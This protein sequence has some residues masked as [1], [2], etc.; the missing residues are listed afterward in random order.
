MGSLPMT[1]ETTT[2]PPDIELFHAFQSL[3]SWSTEQLKRLAKVVRIEQAPSG[4]LLVS[5][6]GRH[7]FGLFLLDGW[8]RLKRPD[9]VVEEVRSA[10]LEAREVLARGLPGACDV[11]S[12][13]P[14]RF[15]RL[16]N[17]L[18]QEIKN[19]EDDAMESVVHQMPVDGRAHDTAADIS[20]RLHE[21]LEQDRLRLPSLPEVAIRVTQALEDET[22]DAAAIAQIIQVD[23]AMTAKLI[24]AANSALY[25]RC[26]PVE[27]CASAVVR[28]G[29]GIT[30]KLIVSFA[31]RELF[32]S[33]SKPLQQRMWS[34]WKHSTRIASLCYLLARMDGRFDPEQAMLA[35]LLHDVGV[36]AVI[37]FIAQLQEPARQPEVVIEVIKQL[38]AESSAVI[39]QRWG[40]TKSFVT[41]AAEAEQWLRS[42]GT[43]PDIC[44]LVVVAQLHDLFGTEV[45]PPLPVLGDTPAYGRLRLG[46][47]SM[48]GGLVIPEEMLSELTQTES[49]LNI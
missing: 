14:V 26:T 41:A 35:G 18:L 36:I 23:P 27:T 10:D 25:G 49:L 38:R 39:L 15:F 40:F 44:D 6:G 30:Q 28:L 46:E 8:L 42:P 17:A 20:R 48:E 24:K 37:D 33:E 31:L 4:R 9:G 2:S 21:A 34:L 45:S 12:V 3:Q 43:E 11:V 19:H 32:K 1:S 7:D 29:S 5:R 13:T 47:L 22:S 16:T